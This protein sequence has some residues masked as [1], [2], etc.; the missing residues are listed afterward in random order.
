MEQVGHPMRTQCEIA[1]CRLVGWCDVCLN[2]DGSRGI[3]GGW[4]FTHNNRYQ[5]KP[6][7]VSGRGTCTVSKR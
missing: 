3:S 1:V 4:E 5:S 2:V 6:W 7:E